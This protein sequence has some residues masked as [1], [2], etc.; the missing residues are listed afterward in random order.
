MCGQHPYQL[1]DAGGHGVR[2]ARQLN[3]GVQ[4]ARGPS[5]VVSGCVWGRAE[6]SRGVI[7]S[8]LPSLRLGGAGKGG[9]GLKQS[10]AA[11]S[12]GLGARTAP[13]DRCPPAPG[14]NPAEQA[15]GRAWHSS[16]AR[17]FGEEPLAVSVRQHACA[18]TGLPAWACLL[19]CFR[20][21]SR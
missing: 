3:Q 1:K 2:P 11:G 10:G 12:R 7:L 6:V 9:S 19:Y 8:L 5:V 20:W 18:L 21:S 13:P 14:P 17:T 16:L 4:T 15:A